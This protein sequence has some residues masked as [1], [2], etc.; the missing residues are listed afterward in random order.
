MIVNPNKIPKPI[1]ADLDLKPSKKPMEL[2]IVGGSHI[3][4]QNVHEAFLSLS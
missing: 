3:K 2:S 1:Q 4:A